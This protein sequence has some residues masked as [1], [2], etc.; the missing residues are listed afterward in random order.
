MLSSMS[1]PPVRL[2]RR[3]ALALLAGAGAAVLTGCG[4]GATLAASTS[5]AAPDPDAEV[6]AA[7]T[8]DEATLIALYDAAIAA[9]PGQAGPLG[10]IRDQHAQHLQ[11][12][13][14]TGAQTASSAASASVAPGIPA[15][16]AAEQAAAESRTQAC[17]TASDTD[18]A[19]L[20]ALIAASEAGHAQSLRGISA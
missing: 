20:L 10:V 7:T 11:A 17:G 16:I 1:G 14:T 19:R 5:S 18:L 12:L 4:S 9:N 8:A 2:T 3:G 13:G 6:V 15:L